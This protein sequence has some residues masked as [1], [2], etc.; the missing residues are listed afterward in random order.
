MFA[1]SGAT[2]GRKGSS[3]NYGMDLKLWQIDFRDL[4]L[5][6][7]IG[8]G[9]FGKVGAKRRDSGLVAS[10]FIRLGPLCSR[11]LPPSRRGTVPFLSPWQ[12]GRPY[13]GACC[14]AVLSRP[15]RRCGVWD[16]VA[17][18]AG[19]AQVSGKGI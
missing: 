17:M 18:A 5:Q 14:L 8:E 13:T 7:E 6:R 11:Y 16:E 4:E 19:S 10:F 1:D 15:A 3:S 9:S 12:A 2:G